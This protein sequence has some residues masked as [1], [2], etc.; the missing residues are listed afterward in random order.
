MAFALAVSL[1]VAGCY[2]PDYQL[3]VHNGTAQTWWVRVAAHGH[4]TNVYA[5]AEVPPSADGV[6]VQWSGRPDSP[7]ELLDEQCRSHGTFTSQD[8]VTYTVTG[9]SGIS[10]AVQ[11]AESGVPGPSDV[12]TDDSKAIKQA[13]VCGGQAPYM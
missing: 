11:R 8:G 10:G 13:Y 4:G 2:A 12:G 5:V 7:V 1:V 3:R 9:V 6:A